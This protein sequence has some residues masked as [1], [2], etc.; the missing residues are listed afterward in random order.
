MQMRA[1]VLFT[2]R[3]R[4][5]SS[6]KLWSKQMI[7][8]RIAALLESC[9]TEARKRDYEGLSVGYMHTAEDIEWIGTQIGQPHLTR[10]DI[11]AAL[12]TWRINCASEGVR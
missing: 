9:V 2:T 6:F 1:L 12:R 3:R 5:L 4:R 10:A 11:R 7:N 8:E